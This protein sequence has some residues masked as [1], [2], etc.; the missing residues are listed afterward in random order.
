MTSERKSEGILLVHSNFLRQKSK[1]FLFSFNSFK[2]LI[3]VK[4]I[5]LTRHVFPKQKKTQFF[6][7]I[8]WFVYLEVLYSLQN[9]SSHPTKTI[10]WMWEHLAEQAWVVIVMWKQ[11]WKQCFETNPCEFFLIFYDSMSYSCLYMYIWLLN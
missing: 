1:Q 9:Q 10:L 3:A 8:S 6:I 11:L 4:F 5:V 7:N 2:M